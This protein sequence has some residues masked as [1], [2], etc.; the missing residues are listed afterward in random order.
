MCIRDRVSTQSTWGMLNLLRGCQRAMGAMLRPSLPMQSSAFGVRCFSEFFRERDKQER[1]LYYT[2]QT[3][4]WKYKKLRDQWQKLKKKKELRRQRKAL[5]DLTKTP[6]EPQAEKL[7]THSPQAEIVLPQP[8]NGIFAV[9]KIGASQL[10]V[11]KDDQ[12]VSEWLKDYEVNQQI[13]FDKVL[14]VATKDYT[15]LGRPFVE[16][17]K[18]YATVEEQTLSK[19]VIV[20][21]KKR[22]KDYK[23]SRGHR[24]R[25]TILRIDKIVHDIPEELLHRAIPLIP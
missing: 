19:K 9:V 16:S 4:F 11:T 10:K 15:S 21:K 7:V 13:V 6:P 3:H 12:V 22:R 20:F 23:K 25:I 8:E 1:I 2:E 24:Q 5:R 17:A 18:V 14:L